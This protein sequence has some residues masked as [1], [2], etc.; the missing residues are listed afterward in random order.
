MDKKTEPFVT[1]GPGAYK[2]GRKQVAKAQ[3]SMSSFVSTADR[4]VVGEPVVK[5]LPRLPRPPLFLPRLS[6]P[7]LFCCARLQSCFGALVRM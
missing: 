4:N 2:T 1:P 7:P 5:V 6:R 3:A